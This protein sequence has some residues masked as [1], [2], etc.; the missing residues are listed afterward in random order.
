MHLDEQERIR[1]KNAIE[2]IDALNARLSAQQLIETR[3]KKQLAD[4]RERIKDTKAEAEGLM[5]FKLSSRGSRPSK[6]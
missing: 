6:G 5:T 3:L 1:L 4:E 2:A